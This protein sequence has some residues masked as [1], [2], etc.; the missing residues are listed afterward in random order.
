MEST[1]QGDTRRRWQRIVHTKWRITMDEIEFRKTYNEAC[2]ETE[3]GNVGKALLHIL[4]M[5]NSLNERIIEMQ[6]M[7]EDE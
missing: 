5:L 7:E 2:N 3:T 6:Q 4:Q 1:A